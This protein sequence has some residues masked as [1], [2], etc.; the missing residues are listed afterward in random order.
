MNHL[1]LLTLVSL[2]TSLT[3]CSQE[4]E[5][6]LSV[7]EKLAAAQDQ[8]P[9]TFVLKVNGL[10]GNT[11]SGCLAASSMGWE[12]IDVSFQGSE[13]PPDSDDCVLTATHIAEET[14]YFVSGDV[15]DIRLDTPD[16]DNDVV[17]HAVAT[18]EDA[19]Q[20]GSFPIAIGLRDRLCPLVEDEVCAEEDKAAYTGTLQVVAIDEAAGTLTLSL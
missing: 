7:S 13:G 15:F 18:A 4:T 1:N 9:G 11:G 16:Y 19:V 14:V 8:A 10:A 12:V 17:R 5:L 20:V 6:T 3:A 2:L